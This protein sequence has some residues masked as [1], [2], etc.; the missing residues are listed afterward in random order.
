MTPDDVTQTKARR[1]VGAWL[2]LD[3]ARKHLEELDRETRA[4]TNPQP[5]RFNTELDDETGQY[6]VRLRFSKPAVA[7]PKRLSIV[8][9]DVVH[10]LRSA[11]DHLAF[12]LAGTSANH[13]TQFPIYDDRTKY[14][15]VEDRRLEGV[16]PRDRAIIESLQPYHVR[17]AVYDSGLT[18]LAPS[19]PLAANIILLAIARLD[20]MDK[21]RLLLPPVPMMGFTQRSLKFSG[22]KR[23]TGTVKGDWIPIEDGAE[24]FRITE[25]EPLPGAAEVK[26]EQ[27]PPYTIVFGDPYF[28]RDELWADRTKVAMS[29]LDLKIAAEIVTAILSRFN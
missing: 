15:E 22:V 26:M 7:V 16:D 21:H 18:E 19:G 24:M 10:N 28:S 20:N 3:R 4:F 8:A 17:E 11:L 27:A 5:Y 23:V 1:L 9:G 2:K 29:G 13:D 14:R 25:I 12:E 6:V